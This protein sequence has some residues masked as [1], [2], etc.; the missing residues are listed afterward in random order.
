MQT[1]LTGWK[2]QEGGTWKDRW[3]SPAHFPPDLLIGFLPGWLMGWDRSLWLLTLTPTAPRSSFPM[4]ASHGAGA[5]GGR[6][7]ATLTPLHRE[8]CDGPGLGI[9]T[10][11]S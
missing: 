11:C 2:P 10:S 1:Q 8:L 7:L 3:V 6:Q 5:E 4:Q 9:N